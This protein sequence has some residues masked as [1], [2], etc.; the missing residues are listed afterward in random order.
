MEQNFPVAVR[1]RVSS[2]LL[3]GV[4][5]VDGE[6]AGHRLLFEPLPNVPPRG[7][8]GGGQLACRLRPARER[9]IQAESLADVERREVEG[10]KRRVE[11]PP[12]QRVPGCFVAG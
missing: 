4:R 12:D 8:G 1:Q 5:I 10:A 3:A 7:P 2:L 11:Q 9:G 6:D